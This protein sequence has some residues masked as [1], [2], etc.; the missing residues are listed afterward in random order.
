ME[1]SEEGR[2][3]LWEREI[4][5]DTRRGD[6]LK[7]LAHAVHEI[8]LCVVER[9]KTGKHLVQ[10]GTE[11]PPIDGASVAIAEDELRRETAGGP[12]SAT[13]V[14]LRAESLTTRVFQRR[15]KSCRRVL[16]AA[17]RVRSRRGGCVRTS[18]GGR[19]RA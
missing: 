11:R 15:S 19:S 7:Q 1:E 3:G 17:Y 14:E 6:D 18:Q 9:R 5:A 2:R 12:K 10:E 4:R 13:F 8:M 16:A